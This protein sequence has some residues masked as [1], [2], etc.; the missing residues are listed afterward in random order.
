MQG[1]DLGVVVSSL[2]P[3]IGSLSET[4]ECV[5]SCAS[6]EY[7]QL[8]Q[9]SFQRVY[10]GFARNSDL[11]LSFLWNCAGYG[12]KV[13]A[14]C[15]FSIA[16]PT[17]SRE[18][19]P[20]DLRERITEL[21]SEAISAENAASAQ[22]LFL[23]QSIPNLPLTHVGTSVNCSP[24]SRRFKT[25]YNKALTLE[26]ESTSGLNS[27]LEVLSSWAAVADGPSDDALP[28]VTLEQ[29]GD[30]KRAWEKAR[31]SVRAA[32]ATQTG[33]Q[34]QPVTHTGSGFKRWVKSLVG[35]S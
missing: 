32:L 6:L 29:L 27:L 15:L 24:G 5:S 28:D 16:S 8:G 12:E 3:T 21:R 4:L 1:V 26:Q 19:A 25:A 9:S 10:V 17:S 22:G 2:S 20:H 33:E 11:C 13:F 7:S 35:F 31:D 23:S 34:V 18:V 14:W 30:L